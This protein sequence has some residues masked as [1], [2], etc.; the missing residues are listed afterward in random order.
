MAEHACDLRALRECI[1]E[2]MPRRGI[3]V[4][5][6]ANE[7]LEAVEETQG[8]LEDVREVSEVLDMREEMREVH[9]A[10]D[11]LWMVLAGIAA[12]E[13]DRRLMS[14]DS[15]GDRGEDPPHRNPSP[16]EC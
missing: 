6:A 7:A 12:V 1:T 4:E 10:L 5:D 11:N 9:V 3:P 16:R 13:E 8:M 14:G 2:Q 15:E